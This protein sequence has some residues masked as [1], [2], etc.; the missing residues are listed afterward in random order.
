MV[1]GPAGLSHLLFLTGWDPII[2]KSY[3]LWRKDSPP[4]IAPGFPVRQSHPHRIF[5]MSN[6]ASTPCGMGTPII[7]PGLNPSFIQQMQVPLNMNQFHLSDP[8]GSRAPPRNP[9]TDF[10]LGFCVPWTQVYYGPSLVF[11]FLSLHFPSRTSASSLLTQDGE[12]IFSSLFQAQSSL[13]L[14]YPQFTYR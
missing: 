3:Y 6:V 4:R 8:S 12:C 14:L 13:H 9:A 1:L 5:W 10:T 2:Y 7:T 11:Q